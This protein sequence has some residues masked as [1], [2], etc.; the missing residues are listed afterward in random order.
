MSRQKSIC[1]LV[2]VLLMGSAGGLILQ[3]RLHQKLGLPGI[4]THSISDSSTLPRTSG[5]RTS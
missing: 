5:S 3:A 2:T 4:K 1:F